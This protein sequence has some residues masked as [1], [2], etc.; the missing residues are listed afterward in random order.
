M[1]KRLRIINNPMIINMIIVGVVTFGVS[2]IGFIKE[3]LVSSKFGL[4]EFLDTFA[5]AILIPSFIQNVFIGAIKNIFIPNYIAEKKTTKKLDEF[6]L[7]VLAIISL[8]VIFSLAV[9]ILFDNI[10]IKIL[11]PNHSKEYYSLITSQLHLVLPC[12]FFWGV[13]G[14]LSALLEISNKFFYSSVAPIFISIVT[15]INIT[16]YKEYLGNKVLAISMLIGCI[17]SFIY[18]IIGSYYYKTIKIKKIKLFRLNNN[19]KL[20]LKQIPAKTTS[21]LLTGINPFVD[22]IFA[23]QLIIGS[24]SALNYGNKL[25]SFG[26]TIL[27]VAIGNVLLP[28]FSTLVVTD[29]RKAY[30]E[31]F[32]ILKYIFLGTLIIILI[33]V[34]FSPE[35]VHLIFE[36]GHFTKKD[37][38]VVSN[39]QRIIFLQVPFFVCTLILVKFLTSINKNGFMA[40]VSLVNLIIN[41]LMNYLLIDIYKVYGL[42]LS[43]T[44]VLVTS[45][46]I[47]LFFTIKE[48]RK[49]IRYDQ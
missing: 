12:L 35:I 25:P 6:Q 26:I 37:T 31:L 8:I 1:L 21:G 28:H 39:V 9:V 33:L 46:F 7:L 34:I 47:Y 41:L 5:L 3:L 48:Y 18:L 36:R 27:M 13:N 14:F 16:L 20:M 17:L 43:T 10:F 49:F 32:K 38:L 24:I 30:K 19:M 2:I 22:Q 15:I 11:Y 23:A 4:S 42:A 45:S 40:W 44:I 29:L